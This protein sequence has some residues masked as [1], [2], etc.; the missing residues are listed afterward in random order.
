MKDSQTSIALA[1]SGETV[2]VGKRDGHLFQSF[3]SGNTWKDLTSNLPLHFKH[4]KEIAFAGST[5]YVATDA[6]VLMSETGEHWRALTDKT[7]THTIIDRIAV[8]G[9]TVYG[10]GTEGAYQLN[11]RG[12]WKKISTRSVR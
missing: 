6:G 7:G 5:V 11:R 2:Y 9:T 12:E 4:V 1:V 3:D 8:S 10:A